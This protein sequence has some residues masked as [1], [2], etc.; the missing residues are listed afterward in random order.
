VIAQ[1]TDHFAVAVGLKAENGVNATF[2]VRASINV[3]AKKND[4]VATVGDGLNLAKHV[5]QR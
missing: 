3:V 1:E 5:T 2:G 4:G